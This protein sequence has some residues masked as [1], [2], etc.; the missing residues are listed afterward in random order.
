[1]KIAQKNK[2]Q[3]SLSNGTYNPYSMAGAMLPEVYQSLTDPT[4]QAANAYLTHDLTVNES[5][6]DLLRVETADRQLNTNALGQPILKGEFDNGSFIK[7]Q[8]DKNALPEAIYVVKPGDN[9]IQIAKKVQSSV[10]ELKSLYF[11]YIL[12]VQLNCNNFYIG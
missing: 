12:M 1:M 4:M 6:N 10:D 5:E 2:W 11:I 3:D 7:Y 8:K 9:Y